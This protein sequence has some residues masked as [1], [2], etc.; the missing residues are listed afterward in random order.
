MMYSVTVSRPGRGGY[1]GGEY[2][3]S[4]LR[5][6]DERKA[7]DYYTDCLIKYP[8]WDVRFECY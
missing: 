1:Q 7:R 5:F 4:F 2:V 6:R 3:L 8:K